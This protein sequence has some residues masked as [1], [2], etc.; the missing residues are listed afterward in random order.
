L[1]STPGATPQV[2]AVDPRGIDRSTKPPLPVA[3]EA[4]ADDRSDDSGD[5]GSG[6]SMC[7]VRRWATP[8]RDWRSARCK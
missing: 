4:W 7:W 5:S 6:R 1:A 3:V 8:W 2:L